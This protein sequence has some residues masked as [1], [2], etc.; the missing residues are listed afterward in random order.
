MRGRAAFVLVVLLGLVVGGASC[1]DYPRHV[2]PA[3]LTLENPGPLQLF[4]FYGRILGFFS[5]SDYSEAVQLLS[6]A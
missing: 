1:A 6:F 2:D 5:V 3:L 4:E